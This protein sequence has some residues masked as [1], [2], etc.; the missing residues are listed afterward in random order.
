M[1]TAENASLTG[2]T[3]EFVSYTVFSRSNST[4]YDVVFSLQPLGFRLET[5]AIA[6]LNR[7]DA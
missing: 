7:G 2:L 4:V 5:D 6:R 1:Q 3:R